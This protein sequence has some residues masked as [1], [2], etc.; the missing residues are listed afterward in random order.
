MCSTFHTL[1]PTC[2][3]R[4]CQGGVQPSWGLVHCQEPLPVHSQPIT[5]HQHF[6][7]PFPLYLRVQGLPRDLA[8][9]GS[10]VRMLPVWKPRC[11]SSTL[12]CQMVSQASRGSAS[13]GCSCTRGSSRAQHGYRGHFPFVRRAIHG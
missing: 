5:C 6:P 4:A 11:N 13:P 9:W 3:S 2:M 8:S 10:T 7:F 1:P 12:C